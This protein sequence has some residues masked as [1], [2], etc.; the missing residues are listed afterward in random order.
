MTCTRTGDAAATLA[1]VARARRRR[2]RARA[3][4]AAA[5]RR[6]GRFAAIVGAVAGADHRRH[7][8]RLAPGAGGASTPAPPACASTPAR[9]R[10]KHVREIVR[11][12]A[13]GRARRS[14]SASA[15][16]PG[17]LPRDLRDQAAPRP[18][19]RRSSRRRCAGP[20]SSMLGLP[21]LQAQRQE[22]ERAGD[23]RRL[24]PARRAQRRAAA[25]RR[26]RGRHGL[27]R[28][29]SRAP[30]ASA[31][32]S[33][34]ASATRSASASPATLSRRSASPGRSSPRST[35]AGAAQRSSAVR[36]AAAPRS[37]SSGSPRR[38]KRRLS[39]D[40]SWPRGDHR[41]RHGLPRQRPRGGA[42]TPTTASPPGRA[43][44]SSST[45]ASASRRCPRGSSSTRSSPSSALAPRPHR[46]EQR[47]GQAQDAEGGARRAPPLACLYLLVR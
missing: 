40:P 42:A 38:S 5:R 15:S 30:S 16:T 3:R 45:T 26:H 8:L 4:H 32:C 20:S 46:I 43:R 23:D 1:Q 27:G 10:E 9:W 31:R 24:S 28:H 34:R 17:S 7:P 39:S 11:A 6:R 2:L 47:A 14:P 12:A 36:P 29:A 41:R 33:P 35:C 19:A 13:A 18:G 44:A 25:R 37:T 21:D 22:L